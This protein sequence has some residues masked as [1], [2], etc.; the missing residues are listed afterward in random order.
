V[1][2]TAAVAQ[3]DVDGFAQAVPFWQH[4]EPHG[5]ER[6][7]QPQTPFVASRQAIPVSQQH[8]PHGVVLTP[9]GDGPTL[10][11]PEQVTGTASLRKGLRTVAAVAA[12]AAAPIILR[13]LRRLWPAA[14]ARARP[15]NRSYM[16]SS[17]SSSA[18]VPSAGS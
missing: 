4:A 11:G 10:V 5:V 7:G 12:A 15:S 18:A 1:Q 16:S 2:A 3:V 9:Q 8:G 13:T 14:M 17:N 6:I